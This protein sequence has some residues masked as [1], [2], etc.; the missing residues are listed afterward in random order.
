ML[1]EMTWDIIQEIECNPRILNKRLTYLERT[2]AKM[3]YYEEEFNWL[4]N[5]TSMIELALWKM[6]MEAMRQSDQSNEQD[7]CAKDELDFR[8]NCRV[9]CGAEV[10]IS[11]V[12]PFLMMS[13]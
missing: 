6:K 10:V 8:S 11:N 1:K 3:N 9:R 4:R 13:G 5:A 7:T 2:R 12:L